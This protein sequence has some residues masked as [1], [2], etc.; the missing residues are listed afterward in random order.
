MTRNETIFVYGQL[1]ALA[2]A[3]RDADRTCEAR[4]LENCADLLSAD[5]KDLPVEE[6]NQ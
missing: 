1:L 2:S 3:A 6:Q 4:I 5:L